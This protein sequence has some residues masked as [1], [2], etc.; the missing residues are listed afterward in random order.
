[1]ILRSIEVVKCAKALILIQ[2]SGGDNCRQ[3]GSPAY[4]RVYFFRCV[5]FMP[6]VSV[7][8]CMQI[9][10]FVLVCVCVIVFGSV[11]VIIRNKLCL[12][13]LRIIALKINL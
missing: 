1:M 2:Q 7:C 4:L 12:R 11:C 3:D 9:C 6:N 5:S 8:L 13:P 10:D